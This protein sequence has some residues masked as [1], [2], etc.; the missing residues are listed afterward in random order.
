ML[1]PKVF[2]GALEGA[3]CK[4]VGMRRKQVK[5]T[6]SKETLQSLDESTLRQIEAGV[7]QAPT[8]GVRC[9][10]PNESITCG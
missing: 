2:N 4:E 7:R 5:L 8:E 6:L 1:R 3:I 10:F 9:G